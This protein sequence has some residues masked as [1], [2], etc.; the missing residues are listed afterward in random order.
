MTRSRVSRVANRLIEESESHVVILRVFLL[1]LL[2][3]GGRVS[4]WCVGGGDSS[5][6]GAS[7]FVWVCDAVLKLLNAFPLVIGTDG[8]GQDVLVRVDNG[9]HDGCKG[10]EVDGEGDGCD[11][12]DSGAESLEK[13][14]L[15]NVE[16]GWL[17][18]LTVIVDLADTHTEGEWRDVQHV[19][20]S[21]LGGSHLGTSL[22]EL[23]VKGNFDGTTGNLGWDTESLEERGLS[24]FHTSVTSWDVDI[25]R[26]DGTGTSRS[27]DTVLEN[28]LTGLLEVGVGENETD[29][30]WR[31][32]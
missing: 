9:V 23:Q 24:G 16:N 14:G 13:L 1:R 10:W 20:E 22:D 32:H 26:S 17:E 18:N 29:V 12:G 2:L 25:E 27:S 11:G 19:E 5:W 6:C 28:L 8:N 7:V 30:A 31:S 15:F 4:G 3:G 21:G